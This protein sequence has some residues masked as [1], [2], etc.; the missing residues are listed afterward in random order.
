[1]YKRQTLP[2]AELEAVFQAEKIDYWLI[3]T[4]DGFAVHE[5]DKLK[6]DILEE[7][8][9]LTDSMFGVISEGKEFDTLTHGVDFS[10]FEQPF[11]IRILNLEKVSLNKRKI[12]QSIVNAIKKFFEKRGKKLKMDSKNPNTEFYVLVGQDSSFFCLK[13]LEIDKKQFQRKPID[14]V[15]PRI[16]R[17]L[18]NLS[19]IR[20]G[21]K[22]L[23]PCCGCG[24]LLVE[25]ATIGCKVYGVEEDEKKVERARKNLEKY[26]FYGSVKKGSCKNLEKI[27]HKRNWF[28]GVVARLRDDNIDECLKSIERVLKPNCCLVLEADRKTKLESK[29]LMLIELHKEMGKIIYVF[30]KT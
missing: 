15:N 26:G 24:S 16:A 4:Y 27:F 28:D 14:G 19:R 22:F 3:N 1:M 20:R 8:L 2:L 5:V 10:Q 17:A 23:D 21:K 6:E 30:R 25:A 7:R 12:K 13:I 9:G 11:A 29:N 18:V